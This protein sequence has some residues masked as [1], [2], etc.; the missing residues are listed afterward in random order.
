MSYI[1][2][3]AGFTLLEL[4]MVIA[5]IGILIS[6]V[7]PRSDPN[8]LDQLRSTAQIVSTELA[9]GRSL[10]MANN[11]KYKFTF[12]IEQNSFTLRHSGADASLDNLPRSPFWSPTDTSTQHVVKLNELPHIGQN[13]Q[14][15]AVVTATSPTQN[16]TDL[17]FD[18]LGAT[19]QSQAT[20]IWLSAG[21][22]D[23]LLYIPIKVDPVI[24][25]C[26]IGEYSSTPP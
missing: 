19:T 8:T 9:Y 3:N 12:N 23:G 21:S 4:L 2:N 17:E 1:R 6:V 22:G 10:A 26:E 15:A 14:I 7:L 20:V 25:Q 13:V 16:I 5:I 11:S 24:G 18:P